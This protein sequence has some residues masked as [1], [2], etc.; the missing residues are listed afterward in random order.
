MN[1]SNERFAEFEKNLTCPIK[2][3]KPLIFLDIEATGPDPQFDR[4]IEIHC[5]RF[6]TNGSKRSFYSLVN[7]NEP[8][9]ILDRSGHYEVKENNW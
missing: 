3:E 2:L 6:E 4:V 8:I 7:P 9:P 1:N 5:V